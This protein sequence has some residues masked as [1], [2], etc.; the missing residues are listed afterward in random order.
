VLDAPLGKGGF[1]SHGTL[2]V[3]S[4][5]D[6]GTFLP[7]SPKGLAKRINCLFIQGAGFG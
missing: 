4:A 2:D 7:I 5:P 1:R 6:I 3:I